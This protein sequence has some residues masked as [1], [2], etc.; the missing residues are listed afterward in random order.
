MTT[1][2]ADVGVYFPS[3]VTVEVAGETFVLRAFRAR[4]LRPYLDINRR[5]SAK[6]AQLGA[7][8]GQ[9]YLKAKQEAEASGQEPPA[10]MDAAN[11]PLD[12]LHECCYEEYCD[13]VMT[14]TGKPLEW[15]GEMGI[16]ELVTLAGIINELNNQ[17]YVKKPAAL[18]VTAG[19]QS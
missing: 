14:A 18:T 11:I 1:D 10:E 9:A 2:T 15:V 12:M 8:L 19:R 13:L 7:E 5:I 6:A 17:R 3:E 4:H 16:D